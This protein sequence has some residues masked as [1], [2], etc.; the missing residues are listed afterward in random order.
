ML[1]YFPGNRTGWR[2]FR[3]HSTG[4]EKIFDDVSLISDSIERKRNFK[5]LIRVDDNHKGSR[6]RAAGTSYLFAK[7]SFQNSRSNSLDGWTLAPKLVKVRQ[8]STT[9]A[10]CFQSEICL[11]P[12]TLIM[13]PVNNHSK[14][15]SFPQLEGFAKVFTFV[16]KTYYAKKFFSTMTYTH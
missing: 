1:R 4:P 13:Y 6:A 16:L 12:T 11:L 2:A 10:T 7:L 9:S 3:R 5:S 8:M 14:M 15:S